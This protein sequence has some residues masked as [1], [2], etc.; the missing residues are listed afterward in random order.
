MV[1]LD[2]LVNVLGGSG[3]RLLCSP[4]SREV[5]LRSVVVHDVADTCVSTGDVFLAVG[6][7]SPEA[8]IELAIRAHSVAVL[9]RGTGPLAPETLSMAETNRMAVVLVDPAVSWSHLSGLTFGL[10]LEGR[11]TESGRGPTDL[12]ALA[13]TLAAAVGGPVV[14]EDQLSRV[15]AYSSLQQTSDRVRSETI[16]GRRTPDT[17]RAALAGRGVFAHLSSS[18]EPLFVAPSD[19][20]GFVGRM[21]IAV[22]AGRELLGSLWV[23]SETP[24]TGHRRAVLEDGARTA[25]LHL[26]RS[27]ASA[28]LERQVESDLVIRLLE[29]TADGIAAASQLGLPAGDFR[30][31]AL[32]AHV[33]AERHAGVLL[34]FERAT[35]GFG[36]SRSGRSALFGN[37]VYTVL[38]CGYDDPAAARH[39]IDTVVSE[40]PAQIVVSA[41]IGG[42]ADVGALPASRQEAD[43]ALAMHATR[44]GSAAVCYDESWDEILLR[45][46]R[47]AAAAGRMPSRDPIMELRR[48]DAEH[49]T[50]YIETLRAWLQT[51]GDFAA[52]ATRLGVHPNTVRYRLRKIGETTAVELDRP[53]KRLAMIIALAATE[54][55]AH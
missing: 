21:V 43:E 36:W 4:R 8:A 42:C 41:G 6:V 39:W 34:A 47:V 46:L 20:H 26:L 13:D 27:R 37:T 9:V 22:R 40:L 35:I 28:D 30:V 10:V 52:A 5:M 49:G 32:Q 54:D 11:E 12:F 7:E 2:R 50:C 29:G 18:D 38:P 1:T 15:L 33:G 45:R 31:I 17:V 19:E 44:P 3:A 48:H 25:A 24:L 53:E 23:E 51:Q 14:I 16:L 55:G